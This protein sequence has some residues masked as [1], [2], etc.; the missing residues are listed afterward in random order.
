MSRPGLR[1][2][3]L[4]GALFVLLVVIGFLVA[5]DTPNVNATGAKVRSDYDS[6]AQHQISAYLVALGAVSFLFFG[7]YWRT[8]LRTLHRSGRTTALA[9]LA[10]AITA[11]TGLGVSSLIH[12]ALAEAAQKSQVSDQALQALNAL[13]NWSFYPFAVGLGVFVLASGIALLRGRPFLPSWMGWVAVVLGVVSLI[14][15]V[16]FV[17]ALATG[18][19]L[20]VLS[21]MLFA[22]WDAVEGLLAERDREIPPG[23]VA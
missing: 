7:A 6:E 17:G 19:W 23:A 9:A 1:F 8:V 18:I 22:R 14:P 5:G 2:V 3:P 10:G 16:G 13:D 20:I 11:A 21:L 12:S 4:L 15:F